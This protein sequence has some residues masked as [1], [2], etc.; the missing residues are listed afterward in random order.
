MDKYSV[1]HYYK[2]MRYDRYLRSTIKIGFLDEVKGPSFVWCRLSKGN[3]LK[4]SIKNRPTI[5]RDFRLPLEVRVG[6]DDYF[7]SG[8]D[9]GHVCS[10]ASF[11]YSE[12]SLNDVYVY[13]NIIPQNH[14]L[15]S[16]VWGSL[17]RYTRL[18]ALKLGYVYVVNLMLYSDSY[19]GDKVYIPGTMIKVIINKKHKY[20]RIFSLNK[21]DKDTNLSRYEITYEQLVMMM[22]YGR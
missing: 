13:S 6:N 17:E 11:D 12:K 4:D 7:L 19:I 3:L 18:V 15:N 22:E 21:N 14:Y 10:D 8:Y 9:R 1:R 5:K 16:Y 2:R 20:L